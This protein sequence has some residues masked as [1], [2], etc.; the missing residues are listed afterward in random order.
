MSVYMTKVY[1]AG[2]MTGIPQFN[3]P[4]F[5]EGAI[6]LRGLGYEVVSPAEQDSSAVQKM[7]LASETGNLIELASTEE[8]YGDILSKDVKIVI[9]EVDGVVLLPEWEFS[10]GA[11]LETFIAITVQKPVFTLQDG[12]LYTTSYGVLMSTIY[13]NTLGQGDVSHYNTG[14]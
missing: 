13:D 4:A 12:H 14:E 3:Y 10:R 6:T 1:L 7:A 5:A 11:R 8:T 9:D 2:P